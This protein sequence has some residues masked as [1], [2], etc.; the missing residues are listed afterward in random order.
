LNLSRKRPTPKEGGRYAEKMPANGNPAPLASRIALASRVA[1]LG[2]SR[3]I[4]VCGPCRVM[5]ALDHAVSRKY[6]RSSASV[7]HS[8]SAAKRPCCFSPPGAVTWPASRALTSADVAA[9]CPAT[10]TLAVAWWLAA[11]LSVALSAALSWASTRSDNPKIATTSRTKD[12]FMSSFRFP[13]SALA[14]TAK[15]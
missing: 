8:R 11:V 3:A 2:F 10:H 13:R 1:N 12:R 7:G 4:A 5:V 9:A 14:R 6:A 15:R